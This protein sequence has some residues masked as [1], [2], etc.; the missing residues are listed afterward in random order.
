MNAAEPTRR[1]LTAGL[2]A[3]P[4]NHAGGASLH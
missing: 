1:R 2:G 3:V 4:L